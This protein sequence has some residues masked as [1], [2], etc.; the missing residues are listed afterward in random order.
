MNWIPEGDPEDYGYLFAYCPGEYSMGFTVFDS[1]PFEGIEPV[2]SGHLKWDG[3]M[4]VT[5]HTEECM[6][7]FCGLDGVETFFGVFKRLYELGPKHIEHW[8]T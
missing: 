7:H 4:N 2:M 6:A 5:Y 8:L 1:S 3:C